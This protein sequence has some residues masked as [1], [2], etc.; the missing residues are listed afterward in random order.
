MFFTVLLTANMR[1]QLFQGSDE[2]RFFVTGKFTSNHSVQQVYEKTKLLEQALIAKK[3]AYGFSSISF[4][5][6]ERTDND[7][8]TETKP[9]VFQFDV[10]LAQR[11]P[12]NFVEKYITPILSFEFE[13]KGTRTISAD[14]I[15]LNLTKEFESYKPEGLIEFAVKDEGV[16]ITSND[17]EILLSTTDEKL[18]TQSIESLKTALR[19][20]NGIIFVDDTAKKGLKE[21]KIQVNQYGQDLGFSEA[22]IAS[23]LSSS[24]LK[25]AQVKGL[26]S[27]GII[28]FVTYDQ[29][30]DLFERFKNFEIQVPNTQTFVSLDEVITFNYITNFDSMYKLNGVNIKSVVANVNDKVITASEALELIDEQITAI[31]EK[32]VKVLL[33]GEEGQNRQ[34]AQELSF[35]FFIAMFMIFIT[36]LAMFNSFKY[37][38]LV[39][40]VIPFSILGAI[41]GHIILGLNLSLPSIVGVLGLAGVVINNAI[42]MLDFV[43][44]TTTIDELIQRATLRLRPIIITSLTTFLGLSTLIFFATGQSKV[45]QPIAISLGF[46]LLWGTVLTLLF[47]PTL[48]AMLNKNIKG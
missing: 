3:E 39:L 33:E 17:I 8:N 46:G 20:V 37:A 1:F 15:I 6:G 12:Q 11:T 32:G 38:F 2:E 25:A 23:V 48:F 18:L 28:E 7:D 42:V 14:D 9:S 41:L 19:K 29:T 30:K 47:L 16:G 36:L 24:Y 35:A 22:D 4:T 26:D 5:V 13:T 40:L 34:M 10:E 27:S 31:E 45:L 21:L 44:N 43:K